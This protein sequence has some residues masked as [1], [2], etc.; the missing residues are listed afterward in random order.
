[1]I[2]SYP[3]AELIEPLPSQPLIFEVRRLTSASPPDDLISSSLSPNSQ[4]PTS[5]SILMTSVL[6]S[7]WCTPPRKVDL[8]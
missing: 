5:V 4:D 7:G 3:S 8:F 6:S 2:F 1:M